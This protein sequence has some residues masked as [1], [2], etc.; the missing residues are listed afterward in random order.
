MS[1][2]GNHGRI[3]ATGPVG[4]PAHEILSAFGTIVVAERDDEATLMPLVADAV[5]IIARGSSPVTAGLIKQAPRLRVIGRTGVG[6]DLV[7]V[8][9]ATARGIPVVITP[10]ANA[11]AVAEGALAMLLALGKRLPALDAAVRDG[12]WSSRDTFD[13]LDFAGATLGIAG[14]GRIGS[15]LAVLARSL[16]ARVIAADPALTSFPPEVDGVDLPTL[17]ARSDFISLHLPLTRETRGIVNADLLAK[18]RPGAILVNASRG[19]VVSSLDDLHEALRAGILS[20]LGLDVFDPEP[21]DLRH[22]LFADN[23]VL[24]SPHALGLSRRAKR[25]TTQ[26]MAEA[27]AVILR[28]GRSDSVANPEVFRSRTR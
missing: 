14:C 1:E 3:I 26:D 7:D 19:A 21:P 23:R 20:G 4:S 12:A 16:G 13:L 15:R 5:A 8:E 11:D 18:A 28:G 6:Y 9:A 25:Q 27:M 10:G 17:F 24:L 22:P 2:D